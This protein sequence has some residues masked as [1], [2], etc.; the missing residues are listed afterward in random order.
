MSA[1]AKPSSLEQASAPDARAS[2]PD[3]VRALFWEYDAATLSWASDR[4]LIIERVLTAGGWDAITW[5]RTQAGDAA[6]RVWLIEHEGAALS[7]RQLRFWQ[8]VL[9]LPP[10][11]VDAWIEARRS[12]VWEGRRKT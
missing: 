11:R 12:S 1:D 6:L 7:P 2:L 4:S 5:L 10:R 3:A 8:L 9:D